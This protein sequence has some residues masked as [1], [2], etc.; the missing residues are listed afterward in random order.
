M[1]GWLLGLVGVVFLGV[2]FDLIYPN[3]K[4]NAF[5]KSIFGVLSVFII[6]SPILNINFDNLNTEDLTD[7]ATIENMNDLRIENLK[8]QIIN[9]LALKGITGVNVEIETNLDNNVFEIE[10]IYVDATNLVLTENLKNINKYEVISNEVA[11]SIQIDK[12]RIIV[13]G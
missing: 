13:Y 6:I 12:E 8:A 10:N 3:G 7:T 2:L 1:K 5:C 9:Y 4:T 11:S